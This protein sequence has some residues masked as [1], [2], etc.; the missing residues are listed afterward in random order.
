MTTTSGWVQEP[1]MLSRGTHNRA[2]QLRSDATALAAAWG[3][4][5]ARVLR[6]IEIAHH[7][8]ALD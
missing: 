4:P 2:A 5:R 1:M 3:D 7:V 8:V 6:V